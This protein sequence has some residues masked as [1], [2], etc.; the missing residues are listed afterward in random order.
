M[1]KYGLQMRPASIGAIP[2]G[3]FTLVP[4][5]LFRHGIIEYT[6]ELSAEEVKA[7]ELVKIVSVDEHAAL[8]VNSMGKYASAYAKNDDAL[9][10]F[11][12]QQRNE[13]RVWSTNDLAILVE[14]V[15]SAL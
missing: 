15:R 9:Q 3:S 6:R 1:Y 7:Y 12:H 4:S 10:D 5:E 14:R 11:V 13:Y 8:I 2:K